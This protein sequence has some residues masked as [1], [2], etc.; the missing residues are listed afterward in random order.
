MVVHTCSP[1]PQEAEAVGSMYVGGQ[2]GINSDFK[3]SLDYVAGQSVCLS[4][5][6]LSHTR[7]H[8]ATRPGLYK[9]LEKSNLMNN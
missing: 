9:G 6:S 3:A 8:T 5:F 1:S 7:T 4:L 2:P